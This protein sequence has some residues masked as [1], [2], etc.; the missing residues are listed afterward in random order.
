[1]VFRYRSKAKKYT[2]IKNIKGN[3]RHQIFDNRLKTNKTYRYQVKAYTLKKGKRVYGDASYYAEAKTYRR[4]SKVV[5][6]GG[7]SSDKKVTL[8]IT[9]SKKMDTYVKPSK[10]GKNK[11]KRALTQKVRWKSSNE[12][13]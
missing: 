9:M 7:I 13:K 12:A 8:G 10:Y 5:N 3:E 11:K 2:K 6:A 1:M 4:N